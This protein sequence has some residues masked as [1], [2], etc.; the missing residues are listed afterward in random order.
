MVTR[1]RSPLIAAAFAGGCLLAAC[2]GSTTESA[3]AGRPADPALIDTVPADAADTTEAGPTETLAPL[4]AECVPGPFTADVRFANAYEELEAVE[5]PAFA[6]TDAVA[7]R[8]QPG[9]YTVFAGDWD[10]DPAAFASWETQ[11]PPAGNTMVTMYLTRY[12]N[13]GEFLPEDLADL[14]PGD[15]VATSDEIDGSLVFGLTAE[16]GLD[17]DP[18]YL[19]YNT[20]SNAEGLVTVLGNDGSHLCLAV[21][22]LDYEGASS[23][24][25]VEDVYP[26]QK[27]FTATVTAEIVDF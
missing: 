20:S 14:A 25:G 6:F 2:G 27:R 24:N 10:L 4:P 9:I 21:D 19:A 1:R 15:T 3:D 26:V 11:H 5:D 13:D 22:Y 16:R 17:G 7:V 18:G 23:T 8:I 12:S